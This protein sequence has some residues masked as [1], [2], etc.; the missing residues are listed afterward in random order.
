M[1]RRR[2]LITGI[3]AAAAMKSVAQSPDPYVAKFRLHADKTGFTVPENFVGLSY[4]TQQLSDPNFFS[5]ANHD[6]IAQLRA[7]APHGVLRLGGNTSDYA[8]FKPTPTSVAPPRAKREYKV[9]DPPP[10]LSYAVT[11]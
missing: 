3:A 6:L 2:F 5:P 7:L 10:D 8:F 1:D 11:P 9:G 4:E